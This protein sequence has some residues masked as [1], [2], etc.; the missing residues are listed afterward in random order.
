MKKLPNSQILLVP[1]LP[2]NQNGN[3][4]NTSEKLLKIELFLLYA[5]LHE[6]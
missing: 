3:F 4:G 2:L 5:I 1:N 6:I